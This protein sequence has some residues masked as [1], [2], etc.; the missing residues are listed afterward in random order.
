MRFNISNI[1]VTITL[2]IFWLSYEFINI[3]GMN[4]Y[5]YF[6]SKLKRFILNDIFQTNKF[7][8]RD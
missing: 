3:F 6:K 5:V 7:L 8:Y 2:K 4:K 1:K